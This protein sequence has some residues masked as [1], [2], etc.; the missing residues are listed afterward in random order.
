M[1]N[2]TPPV[3]PSP[4]DDPEDEN[5]LHQEDVV[6]VIDLDEL[7]GLNSDED[8]EDEEEEE[9]EDEAAAPAPVDNAIL[10]FFDHGE[11]ALL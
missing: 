9:M 2:D 7:A 3:S 10:D 11:S 4:I 1:S 8:A 6:E 5:N